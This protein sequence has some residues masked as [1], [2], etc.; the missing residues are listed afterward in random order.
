MFETFVK[1]VSVAQVS[2]LFWQ[3]NID[4]NIYEPVSS[5]ALPS[6]LVTS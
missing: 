3:K 4:R 6:H 2:S 5:K 1:F